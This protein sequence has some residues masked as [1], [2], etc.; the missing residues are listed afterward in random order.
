[1][2]RV[3]LFFFISLFGI[4]AAEQ[5]PYLPG[6]PIY[7]WQT[8]RFLNFGDYLSLKLVERIVAGRVRVCQCKDPLQKLLAVGSVLPCART[9]DVIWGTGMNGKILDLGYF[10]FKNLD[11]R[12]VRGP[13]TREFLINNFG[14]N[15]PEVYGDPALLLPYFFPE[16]EKN[17]NPRYEYIVIPHYSEFA[18]FPKAEDGHIVYPTDDWREI[19]R[20]ILDSKFVIASSLHGIVVAEAYQIPARWLRVTENEPIFKYNDY[21][22]GTNRV[23]C[24]ARSVA[25][26]LE[27]GGESPPKCDLKMLYESFPFDYWP[28]AEF[29]HPRFK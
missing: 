13:L 10:R 17:Q 26:A 6:L 22:L 16:F 24:Y 29:H 21:Y 4:S 7:Y 5:E 14:I 12:S 2:I 11:V 28:T 19:I 20:K 18:L 15:C 9:G 23:S 1:M 25:E 3:I 8:C 27:M